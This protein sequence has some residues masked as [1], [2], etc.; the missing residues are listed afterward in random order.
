M[1]GDNLRN[2]M[3]E[4]KIPAKELAGKL[5]ISPTHLSYVI[6]NKRNPS[7]ELMENIANILGVTM[8]ELLKDNDGEGLKEKLPQSSLLPKE[9]R[10]IARD[11]EKMLSNLENQEAMSFY[12]GE[13]LDEESKELLRISLE[14][15]MRLAKQMAKKK[16]TPNKYKK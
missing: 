14:N 8:S 10:D 5:G 1:V 11:L 2:I 7:L 3:M 4:N 13:P 6:N 16:F 15:S 9:E 12:D